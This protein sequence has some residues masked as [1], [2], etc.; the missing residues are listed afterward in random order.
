VVEQNQMLVDVNTL[1]FHRV[2]SDAGDHFTSSGA[3]A[4]ARSALCATQSRKGECDTGEQY[5]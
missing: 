4:L 5:E 2:A 1:T 3:A